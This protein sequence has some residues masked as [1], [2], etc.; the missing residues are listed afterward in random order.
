M[1]DIKGFLLQWL[2]DFL[3]SCLLRVQTNVQVVL[4]KMENILNQELAEELHKPI[5]RKFG[6]HKVHSLFG[7]L[8]LLICN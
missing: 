3:I 5:T 2:I 1:M 4:L 8:I 7:V 6:K